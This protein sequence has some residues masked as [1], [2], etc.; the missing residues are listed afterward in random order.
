MNLTECLTVG[1]LI[2]S[3]FILQTFFGLLNWVIVVSSVKITSEKSLFLL[4]FAHFNWLCWWV[5][6]KRG[7]SKGF[8]LYKPCSFNRCLTVRDDILV[9]CLF[10]DIEISA[11]EL[12]LSLFALE[13]ILVSSLSE[14]CLFLPD[15]CWSWTSPVSWYR[16]IYVWTIFR[17]Q[18]SSI[19]IAVRLSLW[20]CK[21]MISQC[22]CIEK[23]IKNR[24]K[25][26]KMFLKFT[27]SSK[28]YKIFADLQNCGIFETFS[29]MTI[30]FGEIWYLGFFWTVLYYYA[31]VW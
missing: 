4:F 9:S 23:A 29:H 8:N 1:A 15:F 30:F 27:L 22:F 14:V 25:S 20:R 5:S 16:W 31:Y 21:K 7:L 10:T 17:E 2:I 11:D 26:L 13:T 28:I 12:V 3:P 19:A 24:L 18:W 6:D